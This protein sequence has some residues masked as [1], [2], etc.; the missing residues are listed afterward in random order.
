[1]NPIAPPKIAPIVPI[2][3]LGGTVVFIRPEPIWLTSQV[4]PS[5]SPASITTIPTSA[6]VDLFMVTPASHIPVCQHSKHNGGRDARGHKRRK[7]DKGDSVPPS[8]E[9]YFIIFS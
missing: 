1:M 6:R 7:G 5:S 3:S 2:A 4:A 9:T 8:G